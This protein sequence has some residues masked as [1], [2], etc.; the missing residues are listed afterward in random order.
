MI[1]NFKSIVLLFI[2]SLLTFG[3][4]VHI[5]KPV[6]GIEKKLMVNE[7]VFLFQDLKLVQNKYS[8]SPKISGYVINNTS[9]DWK[10]V[11]FEILVED[12]TGSVQKEIITVSLPNGKLFER[13]NKKELLNLIWGKDLYEIKNHKSSDFQVKNLD[14][15][16]L[17]GEYPANYSVKLKNSKPHNSL[18]FE[19]RD[20]EIQFNIFAKQIGFVLHNK[21]NEPIKVDWN[22]AAYVDIY[23]DS[24]Q[25]IHSGVRIVD[26]DKP[27]APTTVPPSAKIDDILSPSDHIYY[28]K[29]L[30]PGWRYKPLLPDG[31]L[32]LKSKGKSFSIFLPLKVKSKVENYQ[33]KFI[34]EDV[35]T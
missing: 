14:V 2:L 21:T 8:L 30:L 1:F 6:A 7:G 4:S 24:H 11:K 35:H 28:E 15:Q 26:R 10:D 29:V 32:A 27:Q 19:N 9:K 34:I 17:S 23:G 5:K 18:S 25:V 16:F 31:P 12:Q 20:L 3:C 33:F 13:G 22:Q